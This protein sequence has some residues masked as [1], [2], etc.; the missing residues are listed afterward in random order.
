MFNQSIILIQAEGQLSNMKSEK[1]R[2]KYEADEEMSSIQTRMTELETE[3]LELQA[4]LDE[5]KR[6]L[7]ITW[8]V[9][10][11]IDE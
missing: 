1:E 5:E 8:L 10:I 11:V 4:F 7:D 6:W 9:H 2:L 3:K